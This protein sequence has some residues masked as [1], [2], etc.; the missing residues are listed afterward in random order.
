M[1]VTQMSI[2]VLSN[3]ADR[4]ILLKVVKDCS[5]ALTRADAE[6]DFVRE[7]VTEVCNKLQLPK[8]I[9]ARMVK[10]YHKGNFDEEVAS[11][12][13]FQQLYETVIK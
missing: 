3:P 13:Q 12:D 6:K 5:D 9:V 10:I 8:K 1:S 11:Q 7:S 2:N 4:E